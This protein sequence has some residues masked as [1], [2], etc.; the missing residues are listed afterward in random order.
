MILSCRRLLLALALSPVLLLVGPGPAEA[1]DYLEPGAFIE[2]GIALDITEQGFDS[3]LG[4][5]VDFLPPDMVIGS[6]PSQEIADL[7][8]CTQDLAIDNLII[9]TDIQDVSIDASPSGLT[10]QLN[11]DIWINTEADPAIV[12]FDGCID[13][14][15]FLHSDPA[16]IQIL[17]PLSMAL[18]T[19]PATG[20]D[21]IDVT[22]GQFTHNI[23]T[24]MQNKIHMTDCAVGTINEW[25][26]AVGL[27]MFDLVVGQFVSELET[28]LD[29]QTADLEVQLEDALKALWIADSTDLMG[30][31]LTYQIEPTAVEHDE[32]GLRFVLGAA[33][34]AEAAP[35]VADFPEIDLGSSYTDSTI[36]PMTAAVPATGQA[37]DLAALLA[38]DF[39]NQ[40]LYAVWR[41]GA[42]CQVVEDLGGS[43]LTTSYLG[44][45]LGLDYAD[46]LDELLGGEVTMLIRVVPEKPPLVRFDG[47]HD[48][49]ILAEGLGIEFYPMVR[50]RFA[51]LATV[52]IDISA[53][54]DL[55]LAPDDALQIDVTLD[56]DKLNPRITYNEIAEDLNPA[57]EK[58]FPGFVTV[59]IDSV[60]GSALENIAMGMPTF[61]GIGLTSLEAY[62]L[63]NSSSLLDWLALYIGLGETTGGESSGCD[64]CGDE[65]GCGAEGCGEEGCGGEGCGG[66]EGCDIESQMADSGCSGE[67]SEL[68]DDTGC[69]GCRIVAHKSTTGKWTIR[70]THDGVRAHPR[71]G[72]R[73]GPLQLVLALVPVVFLH[74][75]R[76]RR[77]EL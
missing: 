21:F 44:L 48:V 68:P 12:S 4:L 19:D 61:S 54:V 37:Y 40:A 64:G 50:D 35:C 72:F 60:G 58:N 74:R 32:A 33:F 69:V 41:G 1:E 65:L 8:L 18:A 10:L 59:I 29:E 5:V 28:T 53:G 2:E 13:Y 30:S 39:A 6:I 45:M 17:M 23:E 34:S 20:E 42:I 11:L 25:L 51:R 15:C 24:A 43:A 70:V 55:G 3:M 63:G 52:A 73:P 49:E 7:F 75:R 47:D 56:T 26:S 14:I 36:P 31:E 76:R 46:R 22:L 9:H 16:N 27:N 66:E 71:R 62:G 38:D 67:G 57:F 77:S